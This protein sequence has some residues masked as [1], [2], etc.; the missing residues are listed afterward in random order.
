MPALAVLGIGVRGDL[1]LPLANADELECARL[2]KATHMGTRLRRNPLEYKL[3][4]LNFFGR[5]P[6]CGTRFRYRRRS[7]ALNASMAVKQE[8]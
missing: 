3:A 8:D 5:T 6:I 4:E 2:E 1:E 7:V